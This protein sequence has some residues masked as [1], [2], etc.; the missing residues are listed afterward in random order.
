MKKVKA[1]KLMV[2][3]IAGMMA[4]TGCSSGGNQAAGE[5]K[6]AYTIGIS[7]LAE[8][9]ALDDARRGFEDGLKELGV[10]ADIIYQNAQGDIPNTV[11]ISQKLV[12][13]KVDL[14][15]AIATPAAQ[16]AKQATSD[17]PILFSAVTDPVQSEI[18]ADWEKVG[19]NITGT[20]DMADVAAQLKMFK[21]IDPSIE[22]IGIIYNTSEANSE[23]QIKDVEKY[24]PA[25]GLKVETIGVS[26]VSEMPQALDSLLNKVDALYVISDNLVAASV[27]LVNQKL[28]DKKMISVCAEESQ[29]GGGI[30]VTNGLSY[31]EL[32]KQTAKMAKEILVDGKSV[33]DIPVGMAEKT[34]T[35]VNEK[36]LEALGLDTNLPLFKN[37]VKVGK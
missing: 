24:A 30:L 2:V 28:L 15:Y 23:I 18:V 26:N 12:K 1:S 9:P 14:I 11:A 32:G 13:D 31:Y 34:I 22:T 27:E 4:L 16:S 6:A 8:H 33:S 25:E 29:V 3:A 20:S 37:A 36:S 7:Q 21:E 17:I 35:T 10:D 5:T 19:G